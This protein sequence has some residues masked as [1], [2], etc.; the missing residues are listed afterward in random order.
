M[1]IKKNDLVVVI[2]GDDRDRSKPHKVI[3]VFPKLGKALVQG[4]NVV[5]KHIRKSKDY[6]RGARI[7]KEAPVPISKIMLICQNCN[8]PTRTS[9]SYKEIEGIKKKVELCKKCKQ[10]V[11]VEEVTKI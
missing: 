4:V 5:T 1:T 9:I 2:S 10:E 8:K 6:P 3:R 7:Q 11:R